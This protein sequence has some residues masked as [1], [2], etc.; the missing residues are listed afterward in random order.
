MDEPWNGRQGERGSSAVGRKLVL[1]L[2]IQ[3]RN[4]SAQEGRG[5]SPADACQIPDG[6]SGPEVRSLQG[7]KPPKSRPIHMAGLKPRPSVGSTM[8]AEFS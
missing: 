8:R 6:P 1:N 3:R 4:M 2:K 5:F 7:L